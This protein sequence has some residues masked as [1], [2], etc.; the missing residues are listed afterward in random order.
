MRIIKITAMTTRI[1]P[2]A[3]K[4]SAISTEFVPA[5]AMKATKLNRTAK[6]TLF[7]IPG[8]LDNKGTNVMLKVE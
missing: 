2:S 4:V 6:S 7:L 5:F 3:R 8:L 1:F